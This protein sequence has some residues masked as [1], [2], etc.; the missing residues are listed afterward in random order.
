MVTLKALVN[1]NGDGKVRE[2]TAL[3]HFPS[4]HPEFI[5]QS[6][7]TAPFACKEK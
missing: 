4:S 3:Q 2:T 6:S 5:S 1:V 7:L